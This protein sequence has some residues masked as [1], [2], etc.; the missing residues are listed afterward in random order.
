MRGRVVMA[1]AGLTVAA[2]VA[3]CGGGSGAT[4]ILLSGSSSVSKAAVHTGA[5]DD[6]ARGL[7]VSDDAL[8]FKGQVEQI[9]R[10]EDPLG[11]ALVLASCQGLTEVA[12]QDRQYEGDVIP[13]SAEEWEDYLNGAVSQYAPIY[14]GQVSSRVDQFNNAA[15]L[16]NINPNAARLYVNACVRGKR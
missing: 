4:K 3:G 15:Q 1:V 13:P 10:S 16:A 2:A 7:G 5:L 8:A 12:D 9:A 14:A 11:E 6:I